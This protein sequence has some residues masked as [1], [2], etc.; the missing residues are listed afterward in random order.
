M[1]ASEPSRLVPQQRA[2]SERAEIVG[3]VEARREAPGILHEELMTV[4]WLGFGLGL[5]RRV[6]ELLQWSL[7]KKVPG[8][9]RRGSAR[10]GA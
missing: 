5:G 9:L 2:A 10:S 3:P 7:R 4:S 1:N 8:P 6:L